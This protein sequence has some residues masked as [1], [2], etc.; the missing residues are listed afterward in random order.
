[1]I[2]NLKGIHETVNY[3]PNTNLRL[4]DNDEY[5]D[6]PS[7]WH[8]PL[9]IIMPT[10]NEYTIDCSGY[11]FSLNTWDIIIICPGVIHS[12]YAPSIGR[13]M[14]FQIEL[15]LLYSLKGFES[16]LS[17]LSPAICFTPEL[18]PELHPLLKTLLLAIKEE[19][20]EDAPL[21]E[22][23]I[24][25][26]VIA[27]FVLIGR[28]QKQP[29]VIFDGKGRKQKEYTEKFLCICKYI[30]E[31]CTESLTLDEVAK[32]AGFSKYHFTRLFKQFTNTSFYKYVNVK[33]I[34][35]AETLLIN[36]ELSITE[37]AYQCGYTSISAFIRMFKLH[38]CCTPTEFRDMYTH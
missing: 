20:T 14:I 32:I 12:L 31:H 8:T 1:M 19:Y 38:K 3:K 27:L 15:G 24:Y 11:R 5:E 25:S 6:Y 26:K 30:T 28:N 36:P 35:V 2:E 17:L 29:A 23:M 16:T 13:R 34:S 22:A 7:H 9:E 18:T 33:R 21:S 10:E 4:Y 37:V